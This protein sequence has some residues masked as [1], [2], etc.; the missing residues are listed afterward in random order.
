M[1]Y[2]ARELERL[3]NEG[4]LTGTILPVEQTVAIM[5]TLDEVRRQIGLRYP[6]E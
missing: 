5:E 2:Q 6:D 1:E 3:V 4:K